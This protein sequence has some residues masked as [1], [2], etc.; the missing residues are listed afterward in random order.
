MDSTLI[1]RI[2]INFPL[3]V[4]FV[5]ILSLFPISFCEL[6]TECFFVMVHTNNPS[7]I[8]LNIGNIVRKTIDT[9]KTIVGLRCYNNMLVF[10]IPYYYYCLQ[11]GMKLIDF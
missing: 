10:N 3:Y 9:N 6:I 11:V 1:S 7:K 5:D 2:F 4:Y 8:V